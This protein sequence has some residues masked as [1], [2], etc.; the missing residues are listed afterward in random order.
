[1]LRHTAA[2]YGGNPTVIGYSVMVEPNAYARRG[3][4]DP[5]DF[6]AQFAGTLDDVNGLYALAVAAIREVDPETPILLEPEGFGNV[7]WLSYLT[8]IADEHVVYTAH[9]YTPFDYT[10]EQLANASY[11]GQY[12][13]DG[14]V[15]NV[16]AAFLASYLQPLQA[17]VDAHGV[18]VALTEFGVHR[19]AANAATYLTDRIAIQDQLGS[20]AVWVWQ[21]AGFI[22]PFNMHDPSPLLDVLKASWSTNCRRATGGGGEGTAVVAGS[23][24][25]LTRGGKVGK[26]LPK[27]LVTVGS[28][29]GLT[30]R[31]PGRGSYEL[32]VASGPQHI[33]AARP[34]RTCLV[35][36]VDGPAALD[37]VLTAG[38]RRTVDVFCRK[39]AR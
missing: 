39:I 34:G 16:D 17:Y 8:P 22:D 29:T 23:A 1:M 38:E 2:R 35:G 20:W 37:V 28:A 6:Y 32:E 14:T 3:F 25:K 26:P 9:D 4:I 19:T 24:R 11:P 18:P 13:V 27:V 5:P 31:R 30:S 15:R 7:N 10:H 12:D 36:A 21:P 33:T